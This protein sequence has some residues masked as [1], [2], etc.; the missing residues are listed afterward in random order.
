[1]KPTPFQSPRLP[2]PKAPYSQAVRA[3]DFLFISGQVGVHPTTNEMVLDSFEAQVEQTLENL[4]TIVEDAGRTLADVVKTSVF[5]ADIE[6]FAAFN[7]V[8][9]RY[10]GDAPPARS[11]F[12]ASRLPFGAL[13]EIE[14]IVWMGK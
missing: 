6:Q 9:K 4:K 13:V 11:A 14:A 5:L 7:G 8:Y 3:G 12:Q 2:R 1:M 10:F